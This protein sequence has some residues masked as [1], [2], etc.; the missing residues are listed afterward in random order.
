VDVAGVL[1]ETGA[2]ILVCYLAVASERA[3]RHY[4][5]ACLDTGVALVNCVPV[6][7]GADEDGGT[8]GA[9][10]ACGDGAG[11]EPAEAGRPGEGP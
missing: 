5:Q 6:F 2:E 10:R 8:D 3:V 1:R 4:A 9:D 11:A 7:L